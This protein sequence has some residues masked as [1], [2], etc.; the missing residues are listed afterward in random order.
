M[1]QKALKVRNMS[2]NSIVAAAPMA[3]IT[4]MI[5]RSILRLFN[6]ESLI[7]TEM[8]SS[9]ALQQKK[10]QRIVQVSNNDRPIAFQL[11]GHKPELML[12]SAL[13]LLEYADMIDIN[14]GCP[15]PKIVKIGDGSALMKTPDI[16]SKIVKTMSSELPIPV[17]VKFRLGWDHNSLNCVD[18]AKLMEDSGADLITI[19]GRTRSQMYTGKANWE[20]IAEVKKAVRIPVIANGDITSPQLAQQCMDITGCD[21]VAIGRGLL[22]NPW[23]L[24]IIDKYFKTGQIMSEPSVIDR[25]DMSLYHCRMLMEFLGERH[26]IQHCRKFFGWY[27]KSVPNAAK[28]RNILTQLESYKDIVSVIE[29][30]K[31]LVSLN[32]AK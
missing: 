5:Y 26:G 10:I 20:M 11:S 13:S 30:I 19:H 32:Y 3:G 14:M 27:I 12:K 4:D 15:T 24:N 29:E 21:G 9:E 17:S 2:I 31:D 25:L 22:G 23:L 16:A 7:V 1:P 8:I 28:Y 18:F 6:K